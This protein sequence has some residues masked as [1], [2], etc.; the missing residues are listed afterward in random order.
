MRQLGKILKAFFS[1]KCAQYLILVP[2]YL[3]NKKQK[4]QFI[5]DTKKFLK[6]KIE[7]QHPALRDDWDSLSKQQK[8]DAMLVWDINKKRA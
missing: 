4:K 3:D 2:K 7:I 1:R 5:E 6:E 8:T